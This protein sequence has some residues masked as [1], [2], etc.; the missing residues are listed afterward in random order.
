MLLL[1]VFHKTLVDF[2]TALGKI[3]SSH[4]ESKH[5]SHHLYFFYQV[6]RFQLKRRLSL[7]KMEKEWPKFK[8]PSFI[9]IQQIMRVTRWIVLP[10]LPKVIYD[11]FEGI[12]RS[13]KTIRQITQMIY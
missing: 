4:S 12:V 7:V 6:W 2:S 13:G 9:V 10:L 11:F 5:S 3:S 1:Q 8:R